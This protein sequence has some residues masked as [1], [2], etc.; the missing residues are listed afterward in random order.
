VRDELRRGSDV[1]HIV[2][3]VN[4]LTVEDLSKH[5]V[6]EYAIDDEEN[7]PDETYVRPVADLPVD[8]L[9]NRV[10]ATKL[11]LS[12]GSQVWSVLGC[13]SLRSARMNQQFLSVSVL[14]HGEQ[15]FLARYFDLDFMRKSNG[16]GAFAAFLGL[17][18]DEVFP[19]AYD[20][21]EVAVN[22]PEA[23]RGLIPPEA[24]EKLSDDE[25][26]ELALWD[27]DLPL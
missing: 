27:E 9:E 12:N 18:V 22:R 17:T 11:R 23:L 3:P 14:R 2:K 19:M 4:Q 25:L 15:F 8:S 10:V 13:V 24:E 1:A 16:P 7:V 26:H 21:S 20:I 5:P 6:W